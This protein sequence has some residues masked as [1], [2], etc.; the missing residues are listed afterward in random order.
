MYSNTT[1]SGNTAI[2]ANVLYLNTTGSNNVAIGDSAGYQNIGNSNIF[3]GKKAG[4]NETT[5]SNKLYIGNAA[6][7]TIL[8]GDMST[9]QILIGNTNPAAYTFKGT[10]KLYVSGGI[11]ADSIR[12]ALTADWADYVFDENYPL[13][14][15]EEVE[16]YVTQHKHLPHVP[17]A[18]NV[19]ETGVNVVEMS[20]TLL[21]KIEEN[22]LYLI[23]QNQAIKAQQN[24]I[25]ALQKALDLQS[26]KN[27]QLDQQLQQQQQQID[28]LLKK[29]N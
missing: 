10:R 3:I 25:D 15:I 18:A 9:G 20:S 23:Q 5:A 7:G 12:L 14:T 16:Q 17:S 29:L 11:L 28:L 27:K 24:K 1:G 4:Y 19:K 21:E 26:E 13:L 6:A 8:Y 22:T 2:G